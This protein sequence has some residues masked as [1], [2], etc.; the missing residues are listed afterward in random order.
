MR[1]LLLIPVVLSAL[2]FAGGQAVRGGLAEDARVGVVA[3]RQGTAM[4]RPVGKERWTPLG[5]RGV[6]LPGDQVRTSARGANAVEVRLSGNGGVVL[7]PGGGSLFTPP[8][9]PFSKGRF[10]GSWIAS[11]PGLS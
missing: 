5:A 7:G 1:A 9:G 10:H 8:R 2:S 4:V 3:D 6:L 11:R